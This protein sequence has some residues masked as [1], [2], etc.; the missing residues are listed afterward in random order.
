MHITEFQ[1]INYRSM[2]MA[3]L[4]FS[5]GVNLLWGDNAQG[6]T[7]LLEALYTFARGKSFRGAKDDELCRFG[8][9]GYAL[10]LSCQTAARRVTLAYRYE[11]GRRERLLG[12]APVARL[13]EMIGHF[14]AVLFYP[15]HLQLVKGGPGERRLFLNIAISQLDPLYLTALSRYEKLLANRNILLRQA[16]KGAPLD[17]DLLYAYSEGMARE[18]ER[19]FRTRAEYIAHL[20]EEAGVL[21][22]ALSGEREKLALDYVSDVGGDGGFEDH[23]R[24]LTH[25]VE[26]EVGAGCTLFGVQRDE[27][28]IL[29]NGHEART[30]A[31][32]GQ[33]RSVVLALK[34]GEG[35]AARRQSGEYPVFL[36]DDVLSEL[37]EGRRAFILRGAGERQMIMTSC[38]R[39]G[40]EGVAAREIHVR[41]GNYEA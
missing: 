6:K 8:T 32:Q 16:Q 3:A 34:L 2:E 1:A 4:T 7:N 14:R 22:S 18:G 10:S 33:A 30:Y 29:I 11:D 28:R 23:L 24:R 37:D 26:R 39:R 36:F 31:S 15:D 41:D 40:F 38:E 35:E 21:L 25:A 5:P 20:S 9:R 19:I 13:A 27:M 17:R 12:G